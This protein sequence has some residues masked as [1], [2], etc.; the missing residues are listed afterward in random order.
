MNHPSVRLNKLLFVA[1]F[2]VFRP[3]LF[4]K[5][6][7]SKGRHDVHR[8]H[9]PMSQRNLVERHRQQWTKRSLGQQC[10]RGRFQ[11]R[12]WPQCAS[13]LT[14]FQMKLM[15]VICMMKSTM[16]REFEHDKE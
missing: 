6:T 8:E 12:L 5:D 15:K 1:F 4:V 13:I 14:Q 9:Q 10:N 2:G 7:P 11:Q 3:R 16:D